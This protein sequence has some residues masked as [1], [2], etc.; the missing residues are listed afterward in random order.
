MAVTVVRPP[1]DLFSSPYQR[2][3]DVSVYAAANVI[4]MDLYKLTAIFILDTVI[5]KVQLQIKML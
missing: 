5:I 4:T 2:Y 3:R 1:F